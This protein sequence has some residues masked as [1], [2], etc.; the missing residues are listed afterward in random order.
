MGEDSTKISVRDLIRLK[1]EVNKSIQYGGYNAREIQELGRLNEE[2]RTNLGAELANI[3]KVWWIFPTWAMAV[4][5]L[6]AVGSFL[7][8]DGLWG[9]VL[10]ALVTIYCAMQVAYRLG[11]GYGFTC[12][13][14]EGHEQGVHRV[15]GI[16]P[17]EAHD[18]DERATEMEMD[19]RLLG[20][21]KGPA[22]RPP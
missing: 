7:Y 17:V 10:S 22:K 11:V 4:G 20:E 8:F 16:S 3:T 9:R 2:Q 21:R 5:F 14:Q 15:L 19:D 13:Y 12:G 1:H 18:I 6:A